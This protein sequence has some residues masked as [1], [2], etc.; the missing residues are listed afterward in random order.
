MQLI[1]MKKICLIVFVCLLF[2]ACGEEETTDLTPQL[3]ADN[4]QEEFFSTLFS[5]CG[6]TFIGGA[7]F[8]DDPEHTLVDTELRATISTCTEEKIEVD[9]VRGGDTWH[10]TWV[11][12]MRDE[13]LHLYHDH[14]G[15]Q[16][17][18][19]LA[20]DH[21][22]GYGGYAD[23]RGSSTTQYFP[24]DEYTAEILPEASTNVWMIE[25]NPEEGTMVYYLERNQEPR[26]R[27]ELTRN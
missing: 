15:E 14:V 2:A 27:A 3:P 6:E 4:P 10:A 21:N 25:L 22:T 17:E 11:L 13:G 26:F 12:E 1:V 20:E 8:P 18:E 7:T 23:D 16:D 24:A 5:Q 19:D 9:L